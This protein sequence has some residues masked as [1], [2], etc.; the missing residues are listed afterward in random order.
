MDFD[1]SQ[2]SLSSKMTEWDSLP[3][4][5]QLEIFLK[6]DY[7]SLTISRLVC[8]S[9][10][11]KI[12]HAQVLAKF[13]QKLRTLL[14]Y[15]EPKFSTCSS[16]WPLLPVLEAVSHDTIVVRMKLSYDESIVSIMREDME[17]YELSIQHGIILQCDLSKNLLLVT[18][19]SKDHTKRIEVY[20][21]V[22]RA[23]M[24]TRE[25]GEL[26]GTIFFSGSH[27]LIHHMSTRSTSTEE[28]IDVNDP[29]S[30]FKCQINQ[31]N[32]KSVV[33]Y[34]YPYFILY[35]KEK[36]EMDVRKI[37]SKSKSVNT[38]DDLNYEEM[39][40]KL[41]ELE[42]N[43]FVLKDVAYKD[44]HIFALLR[45][46]Y[47]E[48]KSGFLLVFSS[49]GDLVHKISLGGEVLSWSHTFGG[50]FAV[51]MALGPKNVVNLFNTNEL[52][53]K[54]DLDGPMRTFYFKD[55]ARKTFDSK[56]CDITTFKY[57]TLR[58]VVTSETS[59]IEE[60]LEFL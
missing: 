31:V 1:F 59:I 14:I 28:I 21:T 26:L 29:S 47:T 38:I 44:Q 13:E 48:L 15:T 40:G 51:T 35:S 20:D 42:R 19:K 37:D 41:K 24:L 34:S 36:H 43:N 12:S 56:Y 32:Y 25:L 39:K 5:L 9:W 33:N 52:I 17:E 58:R 45:C 30:S 46:H 55:K 4:E 7:E 49:K 10:N 16:P 22:S 60:Q 18:I 2:I 50:Y 3:V 57:N 8:K 6:L 27:I 53:S 11:E 54:R 23:K